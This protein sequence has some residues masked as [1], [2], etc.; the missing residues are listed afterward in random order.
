MLFVH[1]FHG[2]ERD[3]KETRR[4]VR[5]DHGNDRVV[6]GVHESKRTREY[7]QIEKRKVYGM[8]V[9]CF[10]YMYDLWNEHDRY[11]YRTDESARVYDFHLTCSR[12]R[13]AVFVIR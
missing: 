12:W 7:V 13:R 3:G 10:V 9:L 1:E 6:Y 8:R 11:E 2:Y 4:R 5:D